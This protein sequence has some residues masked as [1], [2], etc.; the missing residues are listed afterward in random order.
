M[1]APPRLQSKKKTYGY[2][3][4][5]EEKR[6]SCLD[7]IKDIPEK[8]LVYIDESG[9]DDNEVYPYAWGPKGP[10]I[11]GLKPA[12]KK[13]RL[14]MIAALNQGKI[15]AP[16]V[17]EGHTDRVLF[18]AWVKQFLVPAL[19]PGQTVIMDNASF[20]KGEQVRT[21]IENAGCHLLYLPPYSPDFNPIEHWWFSIKHQMKFY[22]TWGE[23]NLF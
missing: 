4:R 13:K 5:N 20:H 8:E 12:W 15:L 1:V 17:F 6:Q 11:H 9:I 22:L 21:L 2:R 19:K 16:F 14:S 10:R 7:E 18:E 3:E 23:I